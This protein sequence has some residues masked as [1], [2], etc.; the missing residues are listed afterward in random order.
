[1]RMLFRL[2]LMLHCNTVWPKILNTEELEPSSIDEASNHSNSNL[3]SMQYEAKLR[4]PVTYTLEDLMRSLLLMLTVILMVFIW[5]GLARC[6]IYITYHTAEEKAQDL[7]DS[8]QY[9]DSV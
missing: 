8:D 4:A 1:M 2:T 5:Y 6:I 9:Q 7:E 3:A